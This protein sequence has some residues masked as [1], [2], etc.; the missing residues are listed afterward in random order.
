MDALRQDLVLGGGFPDQSFSP[1]PPHPSRAS[2][3]SRSKVFRFGR[4]TLV[5]AEF[6]CILA[7][8]NPQ[9][10]PEKLENLETVEKNLKVA[11]HFLKGLS[12]SR[13]LT[14]DKG[15]LFFLKVGKLPCCPKVSPSFLKFF[16]VTESFLKP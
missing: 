10:K 5:F 4:I 13:S 12:F 7:P 9:I 11:Q 15:F 14:V 8:R 16:K 6:Q 1:P 3:P 2:L